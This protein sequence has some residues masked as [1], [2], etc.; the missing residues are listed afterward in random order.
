MS[1]KQALATLLV[2]LAASLAFACG[3]EDGGDDPDRTQAPGLSGDTL[4]VLRVGDSAVGSFLTDGPWDVRVVGN[5]VTVANSRLIVFRLV[6]EGNGF[7]TAILTG[8]GPKATLEGVTQR[9]GEILDMTFDIDAGEYYVLL[10]TDS[11]NEWTMTV[12]GIAGVP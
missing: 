6:P 11:P 10:K 4:T 8:S 1:H 5:G 2:L 3:S 7:R 9:P 12:E